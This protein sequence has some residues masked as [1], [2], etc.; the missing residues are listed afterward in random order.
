M[1]TLIINMYVFVRDWGTDLLSFRKD[2]VDNPV[3]TDGRL[4][5]LKGRVR[6]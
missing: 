3:I 5:P 6:C 4:T 2:H 1:L